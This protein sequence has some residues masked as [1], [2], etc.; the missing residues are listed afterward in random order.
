MEGRP[1]EIDLV[2]EGR[3]RR[4]G[5]EIA[6][7]RI[8]CLVAADAEIR[9]RRPDQCL[10]V[11]HDLAF[12]Q[13]RSLRGQRV[14]GFWAQ[15]FALGHVED[16]EPFQEWDGTGVFAGFSYLGLFGLGNEA[17]GIDNT[18]SALALADAAA[19]FQRLFESEPAL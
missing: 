16:G 2:A 10:S 7:G 12:R 4:H 17:V 15:P 14:Q 18:S 1:V 6:A 19:C 8:I 5:H 3:L 9:A 13:G 11:W